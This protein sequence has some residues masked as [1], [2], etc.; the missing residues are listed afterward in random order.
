MEMFASAPGFASSLLYVN[1]S[2]VL[3]ESNGCIGGI[4]MTLSH[5]S[6]FVITLTNDALIA[7]YK[8]SND[9]TRLIIVS[10]STNLLFNYVGD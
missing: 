8:T 2:T 5:G 4:Q 9:T 10:P 3:I 7:D 1:P 6:D